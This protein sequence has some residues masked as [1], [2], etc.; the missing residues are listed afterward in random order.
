MDRMRSCMSTMMALCRQVHLY[1]VANPTGA[2][3]SDLG[4]NVFR[5]RP[6]M[7]KC[8]C[9]AYSTGLQRENVRPGTD[10]RATPR[11]G[12]SAELQLPHSKYLAAWRREEA[13]E[14]TF[15]GQAG[16]AGRNSDGFTSQDFG[17]RLPHSKYVLPSR[18]AYR[19]CL[20]SGVAVL[21][22]I[23]ASTKRNLGLRVTRKKYTI[24]KAF[25][26]DR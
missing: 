8:S 21:C 17:L 11:C 1:Y 2:F 5:K 18:T 25:D 22:M 20:S 23:P 10:T 16:S 15:L 13:K 7:S 4:P 9:G 3:T 12:R 19:L 24:S 26:Q 6:F 14:T